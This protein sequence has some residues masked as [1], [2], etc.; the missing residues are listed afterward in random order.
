[1]NS[2]T[3][4]YAKK[5]AKKW[6]RDLISEVIRGVRVEFYVYPGVFSSKAVDQGTKL[7][8]EHA[9]VPSEGTVLDVGCG[10]GVIGI[11]LAKL[12]PKLKVF[13]V[14]VNRLAVELARLNARLN[15]VE[16]R[17]RVFHGDLYEPVKD[18]KFDAIYS[19]PPISAGMEIVERLV[20]EGIAR[21]RTGGFMQLVLRKG[22]SRIES[23]LKSAN[24]VEVTRFNKKAYTILKA[25]KLK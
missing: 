8:L 12:N 7:L 6:S 5:P 13:M 17:V 9:D 23:L 18:M 4:Y 14:D 15:G 3:H 11:T 20:K 22:G 21:L 1:M 19:N 24:H 2:G 16:D 25:A 10:Y